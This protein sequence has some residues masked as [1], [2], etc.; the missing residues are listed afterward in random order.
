MPSSPAIHAQKLGKTYQLYNRPLDRLKQTLARGHRRY[1]R[2]FVAL[3]D[4]SFQLQKGEVLGLVGSNGAGKSTLLQLICGTLTPSSGSVA[5]HGRVAALLELGA[6]FNPEFTGR[7]NIYLNAAILGLDKAE[8]DARYDAIVDFSGIAEFIE[9]PVKTYSSGMYVRLAFSIATSVDPDIL[10][11][12]EALSVG[13]GAFARKSFDRIMQLRDQGSTILFCSHSAYQIE[14]LCTRAI[15]LERGRVK[16]MGTPAEVTSAYQEYVDQLTAQPASTRPEQAAAPAVT[17]PG[18]ARIRSLSLACDGQQSTDVHAISGVS[19]IDV[20]ISFDSDIDMDIPHAAVT[21]NTAEGRILASSG[22]AIDGVILQRDAKGQGN[23]II[24][25]PAIP[26]LKGRYTVCAYL[27]CER[28]LYIYSAAE[29]FATLTIAQQHLEQGMVTLPHT[30]HGE[31]GIPTSETTTTRDKADGPA[32]SLPADWSDR[33]TT[34]WSRPTDEQGLL[35]LFS[36]VFG[37]TL[38]PEQWAWK[39]RQSPTCGV[40][41]R[42]DRQYAAFFGGMPRAMAH[43]GENITAVQIGDVMVAPAHRGTLSRTGALFRSAAAYFGNMG[44]LYPEA[45][46]AFGFPSLRHVKIGVKL[47][48]YREVDSISTITWKALPPARSLLV[49]TRSL[50]QLQG[51]VESLQLQK[52]WDAMQSSWPDML[53]PVRNAERWHYRYAEHPH[54]DY[55]MLLASN[56]WTGKPLAAVVVRAHADHLEW[57]DYVG[58]RSG[59]PLAIRMVQMQAG[60]WGLPCVRGWFSSQLVEQF[61]Q[62]STSVEPTEIRIP[63]NAWGLAPDA[64]PAPAPLWLM[65]GDTDFH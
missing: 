28:G 27:F 9:Q 19:D 16:R 12:D 55:N 41:V 52:L 64:V 48:L 3:D 31:A 40:V 61:A 17:S 47:G 44:Q 54:H 50:Q 35:D 32:L 11:I 46:F 23:A 58:P 45:R 36:A 59:I 24:R 10:V 5:V 13:D 53:L 1:Y 34:R 7:E 6:G 38:S 63:V 2:E 14:S 22:T 4:V 29:N 18:H 43:R 37:T 20:V 51:S 21:I 62:G 42:Q 56:R 25:F 60:Q 33:F 30:W 57:L 15:W 65:A 39:Y 8:I 26:L 49:K